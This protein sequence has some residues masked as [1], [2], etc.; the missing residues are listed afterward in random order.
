VAWRALGKREDLD[1]DFGD[2]RDA[3]RSAL[4]TRVLVTCGDGTVD[5]AAA[6]QLTLSG[7]VGGLAAVVALTRESRELPLSLRCPSCRE[8]LIVALP[9]DTVL[10]LARRA[11]EHRVVS[12][13]RDESGAISMR[14]PT[15]DDQRRWQ[16]RQYASSAAA[17]RAVMRS[18]L[19]TPG[20]RELDDDA[21]DVVSYVADA[22]QEL[23]PLPSLTLASS[24]PACGAESEHVLDVE[25][26][27]LSELAREQ[28]LLVR[29]VHRIAKRYGWS[30]EKVLALPRW[31]RRAYLALIHEEAP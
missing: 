18:L 29:D 11:E 9:L 8:P 5:D 22:M 23:D 20:L 4:V 13:E 24:C 7:R 3:R 12:I 16:E 15:G 6:W 2:A 19:A 27:L 31:R 25:A 26:L 28:R 30:E 21:T 1:L 17:E 10:D 14:R